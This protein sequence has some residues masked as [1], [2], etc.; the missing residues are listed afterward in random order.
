MYLEQ[1]QSYFESTAIDIA[2]SIIPVYVDCSKLITQA[3]S[4]T[5]SGLTHLE[6]QTVS[7]LADGLYVGE[8]TIS[9]GAITL[10]VAASYILIGLQYTS[11]VRPSPIEMGAQSAVGLD[12]RTQ[13]LYLRFYNSSGAQY[14]IP[15]G[16]MFD[17]TMTVPNA[18][19]MFSGDQ[20]MKFP[21]GYKK[22]YSVEVRSSAPFPCNIIGV[23][24][25]GVTYD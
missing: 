15:G 17:V 16:T 9:G 5:V 21:P 25:H 12:K 6:G 4:T 3:S 20:M 19:T 11:I 8:K 14:G 2:N 22:T 13:E 18:L 1:L 10:T 7:V 23:G 24:L